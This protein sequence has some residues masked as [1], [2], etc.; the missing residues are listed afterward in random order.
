MGIKC[1]I[2]SSDNESIIWVKLIPCSW[3]V[4]YSTASWQNSRRC[5]FM[6]TRFVIMTCLR[7]QK[8]KSRLGFITFSQGSL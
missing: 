4:V 2:I 8:N 6:E 1:T 3:L 5:Y 7:I